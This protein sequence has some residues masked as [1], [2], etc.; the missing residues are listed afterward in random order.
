M[1]ENTDYAIPECCLSILSILCVD[2][3][4]EDKKLL[5]WFIKQV[6]KQKGYKKLEIVAEQANFLDNGVKQNILAKITKI[7]GTISYSDSLDDL[8]VVFPLI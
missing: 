3:Y 8:N 4:G 6:R 7:I 5:D 1:E 2:V